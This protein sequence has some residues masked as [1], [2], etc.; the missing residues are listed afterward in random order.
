V[1]ASARLPRRAVAGNS[2]ASGTSESFSALPTR[3]RRTRCV[4]SGKQRNIH[5]NLEESPLGSAARL[6]IRGNAGFSPL[7]RRTAPR[8]PI[9]KLKNCPVAF[10]HELRKVVWQVLL[11]HSWASPCQFRSRLEPNAH[12]ANL[13]E[14]W[15]QTPL[16]ACHTSGA[17]TL[18]SP[19][20]QFTPG[21]RHSS[22]QP[23]S[24]MLGYS[25][26]RKSCATNHAC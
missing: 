20:A 10:G 1:P 26:C 4:Y 13:F 24:L 11:Q 18:P 16:I 8:T 5:L 2:P 9:Q 22:R 19:R 7:K 12:W 25:S 15:D 14:F 23:L 17:L 21:Q 6:T 3:P